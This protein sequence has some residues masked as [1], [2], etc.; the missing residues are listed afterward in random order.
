MLFSGD[1]NSVP[2]TVLEVNQ[3]QTQL[4]IRVPENVQSGPITVIV[5][6]SQVNGPDFTYLACEELNTILPIT[7]D[8]ETPSSISFLL[9][10][11][12]EDLSYQWAF[13]DGTS[14]SQATPV[15][16]F[17]ALAIKQTFSVNLSFSKG[18]LSCTTEKNY[19]L[20]NGPVPGTARLTYFE[21]DNTIVNTSIIDRDTSVKGVVLLEGLSQE[22]KILDA[23]IDYSERKIFVLAQG[24]FGSLFNSR[25]IFDGAPNGTS[26]NLKTSFDSEYD[27]EMAL[28]R[29]QKMIYWSNTDPNDLTLRIFRA[30]YD[31]SNTTLLFEKPQDALEPLG[32]EVDPINQL[33][34]ILNSSDGEPY[35]LA[36]H[37]NGNFFQSFSGL[38]GDLW[39][40]LVID[41]ANEALYIYQ[42]SANE[43][44]RYDYMK[45]VIEP[46]S[47][48][49]N[50]SKWN[51][52]VRGIAMDSELG[53]IY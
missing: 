38:F 10:N 49:S 43:I 16:D 25:G 19:T 7:T 44:R 30:N 8:I 37:Y 35:W 11:P 39:T 13:G 33:I 18:N 17:N 1:F 36:F 40:A 32:L 47:V 45:S 21:E 20:H 34:F 15:K 22:S 5:G 2:A 51:R 23:E 46:V 4:R 42:R 3:P 31:G 6:Q 12:I 26:L 50:A 27:Q 53:K 29:I 9:Q 52:Q 28:D 14:S 48:V 24:G 41:P